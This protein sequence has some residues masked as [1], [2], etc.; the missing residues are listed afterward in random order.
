VSSVSIWG[1]TDP[2]QRH[3]TNQD[4][5]FPLG[6]WPLPYEIVPEAI[7]AG[8]YLLAVADGVSSAALSE[9]ASQQA[10]NS[11][12]EHYYAHIGDGEDV[13]SGL[14]AA[15]HA[16]N[17]A[18]WRLTEDSPVEEIAATTLVAAVIRDG[19]AWIIHAG[20][21][22]AYLVTSQN[23]ESLTIDH[24]VV[25]ELFD[26]GV[27]SAEEAQVHPEQGV[28]TRA[29]GVSHRISI[30]LSQPIPLTDAD[31]LVLC[32]DGLSTLVSE[33]EISQHVRRQ[34]PAR[35]ARSLIALA[36]RRGG[37]DNISVVV[38]GNNQNKPL[39]RHWLWRLQQHFL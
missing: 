31:S 23:I 28:L 13:E 34:S 24:S 7:S 6:E 15:A 26:G 18:A 37:Y 27:I 11:L 14:M 17:T 25:Q 12:V 38:A 1:G 9:Q 2:G 36:N 5:V 30:D 19:V 32:S 22:R 33:A 20:D 39:W 35:A 8:G 3:R 21:S 16:A 29:L 10:L 4:C